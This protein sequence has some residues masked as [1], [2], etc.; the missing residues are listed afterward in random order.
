VDAKQTGGVGLRGCDYEVVRDVPGKDVVIRMLGQA[1]AT[2]EVSLVSNG[3]AFRRATLDGQPKPELPAGK[4][5]RIQFPGKPDSAPWHRRI[6]A[7]TV[8]AVPADA[9]ALFESS[10]FAGDNDPLEL[11]SLR[12]SGPSKIPQVQKARQAFLDQ[13]IIAE[14]GMLSDSLFDRN[15][16][17]FCDLLKT[18]ARDPGSRLLRLDLG[19][20]TRLDHVLLE[21]PASGAL[22]Y[23]A[24]AP[25]NHAEVSVDLKTW[26]PARLVQ[27]GRSIR[28]DCDPAQPFR[29]LRTDLVPDKLVEI[30]GFSEG[31][32][33]DRGGWRASWLFPRF[34]KVCQA[35]SL[36]FSLD[37][38]VPGSYLTV[39]CNGVH[40]REGAWVA[41]RVDGRWVG[42]PQRAPSYPVNPWEYPVSQADR[43]YSYFIPVTREMLGKTCEVVVLAFDP[44]NLEFKP[45]VWLTAYPVPYQAKT[46]TLSE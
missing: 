27:E 29:Y 14:Q 6:G 43:N 46:L 20:A 42:A 3:R 28:I 32:E 24:V 7:P 2:S 12:R 25:T 26:T 16:D 18:R 23:A 45:D 5:L 37:A 36:P 39:A 22:Q 4:T 40:G 41:L 35:W 17:T 34:R 21:A 30:R 33:L 13:P 19:K 38:V 11:R 9:E 44:K 15:P 10:C 1:G 31:K 8:C